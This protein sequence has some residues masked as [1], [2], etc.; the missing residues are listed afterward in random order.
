VPGGTGRTA[1]F[2]ALAFAKSDATCNT[3]FV[4]SKGGRLYRTTVGGGT[5]AGAWA[6]IT[7][8]LPARGIQDIA[9]DPAN[10]NIVYVAL[11]GWGGGHVYKSTN[12]LAA[13][14][15]WTDVSAALPDSPVNALLLDPTDS[16]IVYAG[17]DVGVFRSGDAGATWAAFMTGLP[18]VP[19][20]DLAANATT[21]SVVAFTHGRGAW[22]LSP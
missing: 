5:A 1:Q 20:F 16:K 13:T 8:T 21:S 12:A 7:G 10:A 2:N 15:T 11:T 14:P 3:Y 18:N 19:V 9:V 4:G 6:D 17:S 22:K